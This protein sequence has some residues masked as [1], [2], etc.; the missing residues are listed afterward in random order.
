[1]KQLLLIL[2]G[3]AY[4]VDETFNAMRLAVALSHRD[5]AHVKVF[6]MGDAVTCAIAGQKTPNGHYALDRML[7]SFIRHGGQV[8]ACGTCLD[9]RGLTE[10]HLIEGVPRPPSTS[11]QPGASRPTTC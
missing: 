4:G 8:A 2:N 7:R 10:D 5:D 9:A 11:W 3:P 1:M 6:L